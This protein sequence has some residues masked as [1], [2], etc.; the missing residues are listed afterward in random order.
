[1][2]IKRLPRRSITCAD[3]FQSYLLFGSEM[4]CVRYFIS[5]IHENYV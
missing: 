5:L 1:M 3:L 4:R 2:V